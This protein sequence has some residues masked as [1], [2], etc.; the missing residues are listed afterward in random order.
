MKATCLGLAMPSP[1]TMTP[2]ESPTP[3]LWALLR[4]R[5]TWSPLRP[6]SLSVLP[7]GTRGPSHC[8]TGGMMFQKERTR[9]ATEKGSGGRGRDAAARLQ[10]PRGDVIF[11]TARVTLTLLS[12]LPEQTYGNSP[13]HAPSAYSFSCG[14]AAVSPGQA[15]N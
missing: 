4:A 12:L 15:P 5:K 10:R 11:N 14:H 1:R 2:A 13:P 9:I 3:C 7:L 6:Y 8:F